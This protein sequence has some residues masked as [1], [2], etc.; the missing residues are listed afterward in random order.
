MSLIPFANPKRSYECLA[1][2]IHKAIQ[3]VLTSGYWIQGQWTKAFAEAFAAY[4]G[5]DFCIPVAN[6]T[7]ALEL[8]LRALEIGPGDQVI[9]VANAGGY[10]TTACRLVGATPV[11]VDNNPA[12]MLMDIPDAVRACGSGVKAIIVTH[13]YG[14]MVDVARLIAALADRNLK[15]AVIEDCAQAHGASLNGRKAGAIGDIGTFSFYPTK[16]LGAVGDAGAL[17]TKDPELSKKIQ[18][19]QQYGWEERFHSVTPHGRNSRMDEIQAAVLSIKLPFLDGWNRTRRQIVAE[20]KKCAPG[21]VR[22]FSSGDA[23]SVDH[24]CVIEVENRDEIRNELAL[25]GVGTAIHYPVLDFQQKSQLG[26]PQVIHNAK[27]AETINPN[28]LTLPCFPE[29]TNDEIQTVCK[30]LRNLTSTQRR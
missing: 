1:D 29:M 26:L 12:S 7:D 11:Y 5:V 23:D 16:N 22:F 28:I 17:I 10:S 9:T 27:V 6:G 20:Y 24:L 13:L 2:E 4:N 30:A 8:A 25:Q 21:F 19:L 18:H 3:L 15:V 14:R